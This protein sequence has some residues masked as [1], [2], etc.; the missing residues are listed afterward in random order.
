MK[1]IQAVA[2]LGPPTDQV[3]VKARGKTSNALGNNL[4][5]VFM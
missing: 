4:S 5:A 2:A 1:A 3:T